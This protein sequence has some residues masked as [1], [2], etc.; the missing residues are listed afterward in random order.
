MVVLVPESGDSI[1]AMKAGL[2]EIADFF[3]MNKYDRPG[4]DSALQALETILALKNHDENSYLPQILKCTASIGEGIDAIIDEINSH[5][6]Y[7]MK[8]GEFNNKRNINNRIRIKRIVEDF[9]SED[10][11][12][13]ERKNL[14]KNEIE[15]ITSNKISPYTSAE[16]IIH[17]YKE[18]LLGEN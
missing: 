8:S 6:N 3:I 9:I 17:H 13:Y 10:I 15:Q 12:N 4:A 18:N 1:Q 11:W 2:M 5:R 7:L 14:L 16:N